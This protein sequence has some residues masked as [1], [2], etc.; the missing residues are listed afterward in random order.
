MM[1]NGGDPGE[2]RLLIDLADSEAIF[3]IVDPRRIRPAL[4]ENQAPAVRADCLNGDAGRVFRGVHGHAAEAN[5]NR[6]IACVE[7]GFQLGRERA[8]VRHD[9]CPGLY[10]V[11]KV[12]W[13]PRAEDRV[14]CQQRMMR[15]DMIPHIAHP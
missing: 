5:I 8:R 15:E 9:P 13:L 1:H 6:G 2:E 4:G 11:G 10:G 7:E 3:P 14:R 12:G